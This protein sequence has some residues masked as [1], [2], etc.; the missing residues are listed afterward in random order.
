M[1]TRKSKQG[2]VKFG[3]SFLKWGGGMG[4][5]VIIKIKYGRVVMIR[6]SE[7]ECLLT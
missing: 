3:K 5:G 6:Y 4:G 2:G 7:R 1:L